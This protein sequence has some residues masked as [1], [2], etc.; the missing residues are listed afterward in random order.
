MKRVVTLLLLALPFHA[1]TAAP[2]LAVV[3]GP[4]APQLEKYAATQ[5][6][7]Y[8][9]KLYAQ[10]VLPA[11]QRDSKAKIHFL[12]G[13]PTSNPA[14]KGALGDSRWPKLS[15]QGILLKPTR[16]GLIVG[17]GSPRATMW[18]VYE[19][20][21]RW[22]VRYLMHGDVLPEWSGNKKADVPLPG[23][24]VVLEP[25]LTVRQWRV[26]NDFACGPESWGIKDYRPLLNQL[27]KLKFNRLNVSIY[28]W[29]PFLDL[30]YGGVQR[31][32][33]WLWYDFHYPITKNM[34]ARRLFG[35][36]SE[37]WNPD[38]PINASYQDF[39]RAG[40]KHLRSIL[41]HAKKRGFQI[42]MTA[43]I[44]EFPR[45]FARL[46]KDHRKIY[47]S[48]GNLTI[49]PGPKQPMDDPKLLD[50]S[51]AVLQQSLDQYPEVD[52]LMPHMP[53]ISSWTDEYEKAWNALDRK[54]GISKRFSLK[55]L[56]AAGRARRG[57]AAG[58]KRAVI[59]VKCNICALY[60]IDKL[61]SDRKVLSKTKRPDAFVSFVSM[62]EEVLPL[63]QYVLPKRSETLNLL[64]Y[65]PERIVARPDA[66]RL[67][68]KD[69][70]KHA[71]IFTLHDDNV[72]VLP[73]LNTTS[74][75]TLVGHMRTNGWS[76]F[77]TRY[78]M[79]SDHEPCMAFLARRGWLDEFSPQDAYRDHVR[80]VCGVEAIPDMLTAFRHLEVVT[81]HLNGHGLGLTFPIPGMI[82]KHFQP[83]ALPKTLVSDREGYRRSLAAFERALK[84]TKRGKKYVQYW[85]G[86]L[87]FGIGYINCIEAARRLTK[88]KQELSKARKLGKGVDVK[89]RVAIARAKSATKISRDMLETFAKVARNQSD[90]GAIAV[91]VEYVYRPLHR[92]LA[93]LSK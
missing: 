84:K 20:V 64:D 47:A 46:L 75:A 17:G 32:Q 76:G 63:M 69:R 15:D 6:C 82:A 23:K 86:R 67:D 22:G 18:A 51:A 54:Y 92:E 14:V 56:I 29:Q 2:R 43:S 72:G 12:I 66:F 11:R 9:K 80:A 16:Q 34:P 79:I 4:L 7:H 88:A 70:M 89:R 73:Q 28:P 90:R 65:T 1:A 87:K 45:E 62:A 13:T 36:R 49:N 21:E 78:W 68:S 42:G 40:R 91:M 27:A 37:F 59:E 10:D 58:P 81:R 5:L 85:V 41:Q 50:L 77:S 60:V 24:Q 48:L 33:A 30:K 31:K 57:Y 61:F 39:A 93:A 83:G 44:G 74:L 19:L 53:E 52:F 26:V 3:V 25:K 8:L 38:L 71:L 35:N 55:K